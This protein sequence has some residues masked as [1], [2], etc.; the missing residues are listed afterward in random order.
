MSELQVI[1]QQSAIS[2]QLLN[3]DQAKIELIKKTVAK[4]ATNDELGMFMHLCQT[5]QLDPFRKEIWF[6]KRGNDPTIMTSRDGYLKIAQ[7][8]PNFVGLQGFVV[9][10]GDH[11]EI[12]AESFKV[13]H[14]FGTKRG[15]TLGAWAAA[16]HRTRKPSI[17]FVEFDEYYETKSPVWQKYPSAMIQKVAEV[18]VLKRQFG[19]SGLVTKEELSSPDFETPRIDY[20]PEPPEEQPSTPIDGPQLPTNTIRQLHAI[21]GKFGIDETEFKSRLSKFPLV[22][23]RVSSLHD[24]AKLPKD[25]LNRLIAVLGEA[26]LKQVK[27]ESTAGNNVPAEPMFEGDTGQVGA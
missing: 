9:K 23:F 16:Y 15:K 5:Y 8:D 11:F 17:C 14:R 19:I 7:N 3:F 22:G 27:T 1:N 26:A 21:R 4:G 12:D 24:L 25:E 6:I 10:E 18:F 2:T 13:I 20:A